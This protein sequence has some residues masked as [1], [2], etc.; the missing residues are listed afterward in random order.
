MEHS[1]N[2]IAEAIKKLEKPNFPFKP[3]KEFFIKIQMSSKRFWAIFR[4]NIEPKVS[5]VK[6]IAEYFGFNPKE[7]L[8]W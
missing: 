3:E 2:K 4:G 1:K 5:E 8:N 6:I 7:L